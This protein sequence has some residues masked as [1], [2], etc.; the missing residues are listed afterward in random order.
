M[1]FDM[2]T[3]LYGSTKK[4]TKIPT[5]QAAGDKSGRLRIKVPPAGPGAEPWWGSGDEAPEAEDIYANNH[6][7]VLTKS[8]YFL[9][10]EFTGGMSPLPPPLP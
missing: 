7:N 1:T 3:S 9:A 5:G 8:P 6:C 2:R 10:W 4:T